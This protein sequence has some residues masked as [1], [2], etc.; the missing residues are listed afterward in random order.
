MVQKTFIITHEEGLHARPASS[1]CHAAGKYPGAIDIIYEEKRFTL[2]SI[3]HIMSLGVPQ[4]GKITLESS[5]ENEQQIIDTLTSIL[6]EHQ[7]VQ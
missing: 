6:I 7:L 2:K 5:G 4:G 3:M 1:L